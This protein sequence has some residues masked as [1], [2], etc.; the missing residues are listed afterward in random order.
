MMSLDSFVPTYTQLLAPG[1][2]H[3]VRNLEDL[4]AIILHV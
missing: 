4:H 3:I 2:Y 1:Y